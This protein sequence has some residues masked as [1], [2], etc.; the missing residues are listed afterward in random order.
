MR[1]QG[2]RRRRAWIIASAVGALLVFATVGARAL[3]INSAAA[4]SPADAACDQVPLNK[5]HPQPTVGHDVGPQ[6]IPTTPAKWPSPDLIPCGQAF[7]SSATAAALSANFGA[8]SCFRFD[9]DST[10]VVI[11]SGLLDSSNGVAPGGEMIATERCR[12]K[13]A[14]CLDPTAV[15]DFSTFTVSYP[16]MPGTAPGKVE[17]TFGTRLLYFSDAYCGLLVFDIASGKWFGADAVAPL[18]SGGQGVAEKVV[19]APVS[20][21]TALGRPAPASVGGCQ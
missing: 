20:G 8:L 19:P 14:V 13:A 10:W 16:P 5:C 3:T 11:G 17:A 15:H 1:R 21:Q 6:P 7:F 12:P 18:M 4:A 9:G 2:S